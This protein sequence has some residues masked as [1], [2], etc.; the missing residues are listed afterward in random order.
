MLIVYIHCKREYMKAFV[1]NKSLVL[2]IAISNFDDEKLFLSG[3]KANVSKLVNLWENN[4]NFNVFVLNKET[5]YCTKKNIID[6]IDE[7]TKLFD[8]IHY[9]AAIVH[10]ISHG[11]NESDSLMCSDGKAIE[12]DF[13]R[14]ELVEHTNAQ[15]IKILFHHGCRGHVSYQID[16]GSN[17][18]QCPTRV[19]FTSFSSLDNN[20]F[21]HISKDSNILTIYGNV[22]GRSLSDSGAFTACICDVFKDNLTKL[23]KVNLNTLITEIGRNL[24]H[25]THNAEIVTVNGTLRYDNIRFEKNN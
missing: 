13:L 20:K 10:F 5:L 21:V 6:F 11:I 25:K 14:H 9:H 12:L 24:E 18:Q 23:W 17:I 8:K 4:Y 7:H 22:T 2:I 19:G 1:V 15:T 3:V 16:D